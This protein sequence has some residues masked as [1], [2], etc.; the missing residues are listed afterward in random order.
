MFSLPSFE[1]KE[2]S[3]QG[4]DLLRTVLNR[5]KSALKDDAQGSSLL[6]LLK[7]AHDILSQHLAHPLP[8]LH[9]HLSTLL[10]PTTLSALTA[11]ARLSVLSSLAAV[12]SSCD[13]AL[14]GMANPDDPPREKI[15]T[16]QRQV[17]D[18]TNVI[19]EVS[20]SQYMIPAL[21]TII[22]GPDPNRNERLAVVDDSTHFT[23]AMQTRQS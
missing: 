13:T 7:L 2:R 18:A 9:L 1:K 11:D 17:I 4:D 3:K 15:E 16:A 19:L 5:A 10:P 22:V 21:L 6:P 20:L 8:L 12:L 23:G 14:D